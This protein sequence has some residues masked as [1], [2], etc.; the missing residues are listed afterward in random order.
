M[1]SAQIFEFHFVKTNRRNPG[2]VI[3]VMLGFLYFIHVFK[4]QLV[5]ICL[6]YDVN[7]VAVA[8]LYFAFCHEKNRPEQ[9][10][11]FFIGM[12]ER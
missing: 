12:D 1:V 10:L 6:L 9:L 11:P 4:F 7:A 2:R 5:I 3:E 8:Y